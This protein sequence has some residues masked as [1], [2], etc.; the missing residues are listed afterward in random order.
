MASST[1]FFA[2]FSLSPI[3]VILVSVFSLY[4]KSEQIRK[5]LFEKLQ[6][7]VGPYA[8][9]EIEKIVHNFMAVTES[10]WITIG[11][12]IFLLFV[13]TTLLGII[14]KAIH[15]LWYIRRKSSV[16]I[17]YG[18]KERMIGI[19]MLLFLGL[20][21]LVALL[22]DA[23]VAVIREHFPDVNT[24]WIRFMNILFSLLVVTAWFTGVFK[25]LPEARVKWKVALAGGLLTAVLFSIGKIILGK[26]LVESNLQTLFGASASIALLLLFIFYSA[27]MMY[28]GAAFTHVY[29]EAIHQPIQA[30][31]YADEYEKRVVQHS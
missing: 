11:G 31:R 23:S 2:T 21:F 13:A 26:L 16:R 3:I 12:F 1:A 28:Y 6:T 7:T 22:L 20:L 4:F 5:Q 8:T 10:A 25:I 14:R 9:E 24:A 17:Q 27:L 18:I 29:A 19:G 30:S 15:Q